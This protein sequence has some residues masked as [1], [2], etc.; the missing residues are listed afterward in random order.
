MNAK[1]LD[2]YFETYFKEGEEYEPQYLFGLYF[3]AVQEFCQHFSVVCMYAEETSAG[4]IPENAT[5]KD[6]MDAM[7][8]AAKHLEKQKC[9]FLKKTNAAGSDVCAITDLND[10]DASAF[11]ITGNAK[12]KDGLLEGVENISM[13]KLRQQIQHVRP[14][15]LTKFEQATYLMMLCPKAEEVG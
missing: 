4:V 3:K 15:E 6:E 14:S 13:D 8:T 10:F 12:V 9:A 7:V 1:Q 2:V 11:C 5:I